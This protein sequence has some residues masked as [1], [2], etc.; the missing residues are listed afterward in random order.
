MSLYKKSKNFSFSIIGTLTQSEWNIYNKNG[1]IVLPSDLKI[2]AG[3]LHIK[4]HSMPL[5]I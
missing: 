2:S 1:I 4:R 3:L 5:E